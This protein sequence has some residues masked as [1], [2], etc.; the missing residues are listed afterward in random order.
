MDVGSKISP[1][2]AR[3]FKRARLTSCEPSSHVFVI[4]QER[5]WNPLRPSGLSRFVDRRRPRCFFVPPSSDQVSARAQRR[6]EP[7]RDHAASRFRVLK[8]EADDPREG[9]GFPIP[10]LIEGWYL[11]AGDS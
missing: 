9:W 5:L 6:S 8:V 7:G 10:L 1:A 3:I 11:S 2:Y 4:W